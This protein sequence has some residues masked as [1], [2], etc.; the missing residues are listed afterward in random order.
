VY[1]IANIANDMR[2]MY[3]YVNSSTAGQKNEC[4]SHT[5]KANSLYTNMRPF[6]TNTINTS[7]H[8]WRAIDLCTRFEF[9]RFNITPQ[10]P[11]KKMSAWAALSTHSQGG[12]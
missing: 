3:I 5:T 8:A 1:H 12:A 11:S 2:G 7:I 4:L 10:Q 6:E 9:L